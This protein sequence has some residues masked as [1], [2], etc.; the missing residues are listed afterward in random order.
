VPIWR[1]VPACSGTELHYYEASP[2]YS[3]YPRRTGVPGRIKEAV[4][5]ARFV[6]LIR[7][8]VDR[9]VSHYRH[10]VAVEGESPSFPEAVADLDRCNVYLCASC[11]ATQL[12][13]Y[14]SQFDAGRILISS[15]RICE[16]TASPRCSGSLH[17]SASR[18]AS[19]RAVRRRVPRQ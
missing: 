13:Q 19:N 3:A 17:F 2:S 14:L 11:Y 5:D 10:R 1:A 18:R 6:Y 7:D 8:P 16:E 9:T 4:P 15:K 12:E